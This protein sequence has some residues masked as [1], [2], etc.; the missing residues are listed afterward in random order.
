MCRKPTCRIIIVVVAC[1]GG[2]GFGVDRYIDPANITATASSVNY[3]L[4]PIYSCNGNGLNGDF[5]TS[6]IGGEPP[7]AGR[8]T[9]WLGSV[10]DPTPSIEYQ[11]DKGYLIQ[12]MW[13]WNYN[14]VTS[15]GGDRTERGMKECIIEYSV[16]GVDW[17]VLSDAQTLARADGSGAYAHNTVVPF[18]D[19]EAMY[20]RLTAVSN[21]GGTSTG[22]SEV[23]FVLALR[24]YARYPLPADGVE[25]VDTD[26]EL[27]WQA[28]ELAQ[29]HDVY[30]GTSFSGV[31]DAGR[32]SAEYKG[33]QPA[34]SS[35]FTPTGVIWGGT[36]YW[37]IDEVNDANPDS[38]WK[39]SVWSFTVGGRV[40]NPVPRNG[41][42]NVGGDAVLGWTGGLGASMHD[43]YFG[44]ERSEVE[45]ANDSLPVG[46]SVYKGRQDANSYVP[47]L[48]FGRTY[49]W[50]VDEVK[51]GTIIRGAVW[52]FGTGEYSVV[53]NFES[54]TAEN[55]S[56]VWME[57]GGMWTN[58]TANPNRGGDWSMELAYYNQGDLV[59]SEGERGFEPPGDWTA[60]GVKALGLFF[61]GN[62]SN[63]ADRFY[64][65]VQDTG[66][67][68]VSVTYDGPPEDLQS[69]DWHSWDISLEQFSDGGVDLTAVSKLAIGV[70][71][72]GA[73]SASGSM[74]YLYIDDIR[75]YPP[76]CVARFARASDLNADCIVDWADLGIM[77]VDWLDSEYTVISSEP[78][79]GRLVAHYRF[80]ETSG[81]V[82]GD[83]SGGGFDA[84]VDP[85]GETAWSSEG[86]DASGCLN[87]DGTFK[88]TVPAEPFK[89]VA[90]GVTVSLWVN[91]DAAMQPDAD[92]GVV[93][94][95]GNA[96]ND[97]I[98]LAHCPTPDG[99]VMFDSGRQA[100]Q[101]LVWDG[102]EADDWQGQWNHYAFTLDASKK[103][104]R[105]Y[106][107]GQI[108]AEGNLYQPPRGITEFSIGG[109]I[110]VGLTHPY[111]G[112]I[113][114][115]RIYNYALSQAQVVYLTGVEDLY[116]PLD[117]PAEL[118]VDAIVNYKDFAVLAEDWLVEQ[119]W[120]SR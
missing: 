53:D 32:G 7:A 71:D 75:L 82:A 19:V 29:W 2:R 98:L 48:E 76:R 90:L 97:R 40:S 23:R 114:D 59:F 27:S 33:N 67:R 113:D 5:H 66:G 49:Y 37:R 31:E 54:Y 118:A 78:D 8:G 44:T 94:Q 73:S 62:P 57:S 18:G 45:T 120:P 16:D 20:V 1:L 99:E 46:A 22:L 108:V 79:A 110:G 112:R 115:F 6:N 105:M 9:M 96:G 86:Y 21:Y 84:T 61:A 52:S 58:I 38:P 87:F 34:H 3:Q 30:F 107:N 55:I 11:F 104:I 39:G 81:T 25:N 95:G 14:Q 102:A 47:A 17:T 65:T 100:V 80:D 15:D 89:T 63:I 103:L 93:F 85:N 117:S 42:E 26:V 36:Y 13:V 4:D 83:S 24:E 35:S 109:G 88:V 68:S 43:V 41:A 10:D 69:T 50:R 56:D 116:V 92:W 72:S 51:D 119:L 101:R 106:R 77:G 70:G 111:Y 12:E 28:G 91:G 64:V 74:G 60:A